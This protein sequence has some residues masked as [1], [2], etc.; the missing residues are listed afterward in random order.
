MVSCKDVEKKFDNQFIEI[1]NKENL[2]KHDFAP[3]FA[4]FRV[5]AR[6]LDVNRFKRFDELLTKYQCEYFSIL[7]DS[8]EDAYYLEIKHSKIYNIHKERLI[9]L[10]YPKHP[11]SLYLLEEEFIDIIK[12]EIT[13]DV[14]Y[15]DLLEKLFHVKDV[16]DE[17]TI[18]I[19]H[20]ILLYYQDISKKEPTYIL[21]L[22]D[23]DKMY[24][25]LEKEEYQ[26]IKK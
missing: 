25:S 11:D 2:Q 8:E 10:E 14:T 3:I 20:N 26:K 13:D 23:L 7:G 9:Q 22:T 5:H 1:T 24:S 16:V 17:K 21:G 19:M 6:E 4:F 15:Y 18:Y 12:R